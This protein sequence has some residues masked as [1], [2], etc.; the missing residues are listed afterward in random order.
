MAAESPIAGNQA[1]SPAGPAD[2]PTFS[3]LGVKHSNINCATGVELSERQKICVGSVLDVCREMNETRQIK[4]VYN[5][6]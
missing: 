4:M 1:Q 6:T 5:N 3:Q 2:V